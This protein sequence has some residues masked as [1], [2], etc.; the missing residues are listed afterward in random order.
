MNPPTLM[1]KSDPQHRIQIAIAIILAATSS[2]AAQADTYTKRSSS[3]ATYP[4]VQY[5]GSNALQKNFNFPASKGQLKKNGEWVVEGSLVHKG[6]LCADYEVGVRF[7]I[8]KEGC[9][10]VEW[11]STDQYATSQSLCNNAKIPYRAVMQEP[12][13][14]ASFDKITCA[15]RIIRCTGTCK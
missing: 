11:V 15:E 10:D 3:P 1:L 12:E 7:G 2:S 13:L 6:L 9:T 8:A 5:D 14:E 4:G